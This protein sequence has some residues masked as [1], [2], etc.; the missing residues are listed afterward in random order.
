M[1]FTLLKQA[2]RVQ[3]KCGFRPVI[4]GGSVLTLYK[5]FLL[6][7]VLQPNQTAVFTKEITGETVWTLRAV[8]SDQGMV[9]TTGVR[10]QIQLPNGRFLIG[11]NGQDAGQFAGVGSYRYLMDPE[12]D[13]EPGSKIQVTLSDT[14]TGGLTNPLAV[15]LLFEGSYKFYFRNGEP[16]SSQMASEL[17]RYQGIVNE[18]I[19]APSYTAG[20]AVET[21]KGNKDDYFVYSCPNPIT[22]PLGGPLTAT[23]KIPIDNGIDFICRR[24]LL[25]VEADATVSAGNFL[26]RVRTGDGYALS[27][28]YL[29]YPR[30][31]NGAE[32]PHDWTIR[33]GDE[34]LVDVALADSA[35]T[36]N[37][38][39]QVH[40]E[41]DKR[42]RT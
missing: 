5:G 34:V 17:K 16:V 7:M 30:L 9:S 11:G 33:G 41:G 42:R 31:I 22:V 12:L 25:D 26:C 27:D 8:S 36:G 15:N 1:D 4:R 37:M 23:M 20:Y 6:P 21:P 32:W 19:L 10:L 14:T 39:L 2:D 40:L 13:C 18:N 29:D 38:Y 24:L 3:S 35:G 28:D